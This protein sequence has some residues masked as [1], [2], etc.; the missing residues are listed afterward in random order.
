MLETIALPNIF[1][2]TMI[3]LFSTGFFKEKKV[4]N[5]IFLIL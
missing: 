1:V 4:L 5:N 3:L 2:E